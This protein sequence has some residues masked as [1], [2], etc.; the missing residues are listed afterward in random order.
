[1]SIEVAIDRGEVQ[2]R[3]ASE[4][5]EA[6]EKLRPV[7]RRTISFVLVKEF[8]ITYREAEQ[9]VDVYCDER[10]PFT[11]QYLTAEFMLPYFKLASLVVAGLS[12]FLIFRG[13]QEHLSSRPSALYFLVG[14]VLFAFSGVGFMR[15]LESE[16]IQKS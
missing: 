14:A 12:I 15:I 10:S 13:A 16:R 1:M 3:I 2:E 9:A 11:P 8:G 7:S 5:N 6:R 4:L